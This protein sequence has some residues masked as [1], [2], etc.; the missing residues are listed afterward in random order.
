MI[1]VCYLQRVKDWVFENCM[2]LTK[3]KRLSV[4]ELYATLQRVKGWVFENCMLLTKS[5]RL[6]VWELYATYKE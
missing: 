3:S 1:I 6:S 2:L 4:W 5:K